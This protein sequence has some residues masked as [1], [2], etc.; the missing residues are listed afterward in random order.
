M[1]AWTASRWLWIRSSGS[2]IVVG[3]SS[4]WVVGT[5]HLSVVFA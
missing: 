2:D 5:A 3:T 4:W 1:T